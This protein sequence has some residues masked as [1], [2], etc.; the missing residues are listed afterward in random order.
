MLITRVGTALVGIPILLILVWAGGVPFEAAA[1]LVAIQASREAYNMFD[2]SDDA[3]PWRW[4]AMTGAGCV[5]AASAMG[6]AWLVAGFA[7]VLVGFLMALLFVDQAI[8]ATRLVE[9]FSACIY[10]ALPISL[11]VLI[12]AWSTPAAP[13]HVG[14]LTTMGGQTWLLFLLTTVWSVD[15]GAYLVGRSIGRRLLWP[16]VSPK[17]TWEGT[18][19]GVMLGIAVAIAWS[20]SLPLNV[21]MA[22]FVGFLMSIAAVFGDLT[23]SA[24][25]RR[26]HVKDA[27]H[28]LPG[29]GG[30]LD[31]IDSL[32]FAAIVVFLTGNVVGAR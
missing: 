2:P 7:V 19:A 13:V 32:A 1:V 4:L 14:P 3:T 25:K 22:A 16:S 27:S 15:S 23:E 18:I 20:G 31:R 10:G 26:A 21:P 24:L 12:R 9:G 29:H 11:L 8:P 30:L 28:L 17:K 5:A 6:S